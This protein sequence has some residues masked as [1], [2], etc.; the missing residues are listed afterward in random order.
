VSAFEIIGEVCTLDSGLIRGW[1]W[2][3]SSTYRRKIAERW[4]SNRLRVLGGALETVLFMAAEAVA[5]WYLV[6][7]IVRL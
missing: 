3:V 2:I 4:R 7:W 1:R 5:F 6:S